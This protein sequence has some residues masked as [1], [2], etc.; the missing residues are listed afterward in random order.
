MPGQVCD[1]FKRRG[2]LTHNAPTAILLK[3]RS[4]ISRL[5]AGTPYWQL[6]GKR[7]Q[8]NR[9]VISIPVGPSWRILAHDKNGRVEA[10]QVLSH[11]S[12]NHRLSMF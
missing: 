4:I 3:A 8:W 7:L 11:S 10:R 5:E 1:F 2:I 12:Y 9:A 6:R